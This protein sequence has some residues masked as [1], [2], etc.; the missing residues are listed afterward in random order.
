[1]SAS[2]H[3]PLQFGNPTDMDR[4]IELI[5][6]AIPRIRRPC[7]SCPSCPHVNDLASTIPCSPRGTLVP[8]VWAAFKHHSLRSTNDKRIHSPCLPPDSTLG[9]PAFT[10]P[11]A[12]SCGCGRLVRIPNVCNCYRPM[13]SEAI[14]P[15][16]MVRGPANATDKL[17]LQSPGSS[18]LH[19]LLSPSQARMDEGSGTNCLQIL[20]S[21]EKC[22]W[23][24]RSGSQSASATC[25]I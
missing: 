17:I 25:Q 3:P 12:G 13:V 2:P 11:T 8:L 19:N 4:Q 10:H 23:H 9:F 6:L 5:N 15:R 24:N 18:L 16:T 20:R 1:L 7:P 14:V 21:A 22:S